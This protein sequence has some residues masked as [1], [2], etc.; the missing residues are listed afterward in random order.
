MK[1]AID[2]SGSVQGP[3]VGELPVLT[4][5]PIGQ[6]RGSMAREVVLSEALALFALRGIDGVSI[7]DIADAAEMSKA[8]VLHHFGTK[9]R[10]YRT[11]L[12]EV[13]ERLEAAVGAAADRIEVD[14]GDPLA[15]VRVE[16][17]RW[18]DQHPDDVRLM[19]YGLLRLR[20]RPGPWVLEG[21]I[22]ALMRAT[23]IGVDDAAETVVGLLGPVTYRVMAAPLRPAFAAAARRARSTQPA[24]S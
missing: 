8:N 18:A 24:P 3:W 17:E 2:D 23:G 19:A 15:A 14:G 20:E 4:D 6:Y 16:L 11:C 7:A 22:A 9:D 10:L 1:R 5:R 12:E 21:A 13:G